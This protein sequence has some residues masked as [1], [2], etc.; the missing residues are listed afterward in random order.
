MREKGMW[1]EHVGCQVSRWIIERL[2]NDHPPQWTAQHK[3]KN[4]RFC[5]IR[6]AVAYFKKNT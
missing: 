3:S 2:H 5:I 4:N 1:T 6:P